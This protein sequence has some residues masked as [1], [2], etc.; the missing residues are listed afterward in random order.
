[1]EQE[2]TDIQ[3]ALLEYLYK[4]VAKEEA[5]F[6]FWLSKD[7]VERA[8]EEPLEGESG[9]IRFT[10]EWVG[11]AVVEAMDH[12]RAPATIFERFVEKLDSSS[13]LR[14]IDLT[15]REERE[16]SVELQREFFKDMNIE[17]PPDKLRLQVY[18]QE[19]LGKLSDMVERSYALGNKQHLMLHLPESVDNY[20]AEAA[21]C[22][23]HGFDRACLIMCRAGIEEGLKRRISK[24]HGKEELKI[25]DKGRWR[26]KLL[27]ELIRD[28]SEK[29]KYFSWAPME[30][31]A[32]DIK[33]LGNRCVHGVL[34]KS[35][36]REA[37]EEALFNT[38][39]IVSTLYALEEPETYD[40]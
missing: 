25:F 11:P 22:F 35:E 40:D 10:L 9:M 18:A 13:P 1:M 3:Q 16:K 7:R 38:R 39:F 23:R 21:A 2:S 31:F 28:A 34:S 15:T 17:D 4:L 12:L 5:S 19:V 33:N 27:W 37:A 20:M 24:D 14:E 36:L 26:N 29:Y 30:K 32:R 6:R 8:L